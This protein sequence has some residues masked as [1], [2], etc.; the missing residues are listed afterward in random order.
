MA[1]HPAP[2]LGQPLVM[3]GEEPWERRGLAGM[4]PAPLGHPSTLKFLCC[5]SH[6]NTRTPTE[7]SLVNMRRLKR[8]QGTHPSQGKAGALSG[9]GPHSSLKEEE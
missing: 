5:R 9:M 1:G 4:H 6:G 8:E 3:W 2:G 7:K